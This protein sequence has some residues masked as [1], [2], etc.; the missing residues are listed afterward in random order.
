MS[1]ILGMGYGRG[2][3]GGSGGPQGG[4]G[5]ERSLFRPGYKYPICVVSEL[6]LSVEPGVKRENILINAPISADEEGQIRYI[7]FLEG[8][9]E[10][11]CV[12]TV[13]GGGADSAW[14]GQKAIQPL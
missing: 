8:G 11:I 4:E 12:G 2:E 10:I 13:A 6:P 1:L 3:S 5:A 14:H 9:A 7:N